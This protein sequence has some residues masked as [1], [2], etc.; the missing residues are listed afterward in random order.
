MARPALTMDFMAVV[1]GVRGTTVPSG[2][3]TVRMAGVVSPPEARAEATTPTTT[4]NTAMP[5]TTR[6]GPRRD[7]GS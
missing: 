7:M 6:A 1:A 2:M 3:V 5:R 4:M